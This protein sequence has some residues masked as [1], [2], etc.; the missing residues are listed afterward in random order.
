MSNLAA[1]IS[2]V[3]NVSIEDYLQQCKLTIENYLKTILPEPT[4]TTAK[5]MH[6][7]VLNG[8][9]RLRPALVFAT[10]AIFGLS[11]SQLLPAAASVELIHCYSLIHDDLPA[12]DNDDLRR[13]L[14]TCHKKF[15]EATAILAGDAL[16][17]LAFEV[18]TDEKL[19]PM[20][21]IAKVKIV[22]ALS[23]ASGI[24]GMILG[25]TQ[26]LAATG[27]TI[28]LEQLQE[29]HT[30]KTGKLIETSIHLGILASQY[31]D[32]SIYSGLD[33][34]LESNFDGVLKDNLTIAPDTKLE[35]N[36]DVNIISKLLKFGELIGILFQVQDDILDETS[37]TEVLGKPKGSDVKN[38]KTTFVS[39]LGLEKTKDFAKNLLIQTLSLLDEIENDKI[40]I[41][42]LRALATF[43]LQRVS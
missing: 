31:N 26:D 17:T 33:S 11:T 30:N 42:Y 19:N 28:S 27:N 21:A 3:S 9:K 2:N 38:N 36:I 23:K 7:A 12:M 18:L 25:Q 16:Q 20:P 35:T 15:D 4:N 14:P 24:N 22:A 10:G 40:N 13:G 29:L 5:A 34:I 8:G 1:N 32:D 37:T 39:L 43:C 41:D 6:Y